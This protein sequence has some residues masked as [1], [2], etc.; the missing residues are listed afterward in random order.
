FDFV[1]EHELFNV[2]GLAANYAAAASTGDRD[3]IQFPAMAK[4]IKARWV[5]TTD[6]K[7]ISADEA[8]RFHWRKV[9]DN[10]YKLAAL[11]LTT[12]DLKQWFWADFVQEDYELQPGPAAPSRDVTTRGANAYDRGS[13]D[14]ERREL[15]GSK[16]AHY[17]LR[18]TQ[19]DFLDADGKPVV[20]GNTMI[21]IGRADKSSCMTCHFNASVAGMMADGRIDSLP[22][23]MFVLGKPDAALLGTSPTIRYLQDDFVWSAPARAQHKS[24]T[25]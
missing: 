21:E 18:G 11:H 17:R 4:E 23:G 13:I 15:S 6:P 20:L 25:P 19:T 1:R 2:E 24:T 12:K 10:Y 9:G 3:W 8:A 22:A 7:A 16:W 14:G 5:A